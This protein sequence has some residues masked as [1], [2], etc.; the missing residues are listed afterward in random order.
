MQYATDFILNTHATIG[1]LWFIVASIVVSI[2]LC[3]IAIPMTTNLMVNQVAGLA[4]RWFGAKTRTL[5]INASTNNPELASMVVSMGIGRM[6]GW[7]NPCGSL[8]A[9]GYLMY[10]FAPIWFMLI[11][12][13]KGK[14]NLLGEFFKLLRAE[15][16]LVM[17]HI[18]IA[19]GAFACG[20][21]ALWLMRSKFGRGE[22]PLTPPNETTELAVNATST[23]VLQST[24]ATP[25]TGLFMF[26]ALAILI[27]GVALVFYFEHRLKKKRP[28]LFTDIHD[29]HHGDSIFLFIVGT[30]GLI[31]ACWVMNTM[32]LAW[33]A[34]YSDTLSSLLGDQVFAGLHYF[35]GALITSLPELNV[36]L[37]NYRRL[38]VPDLNT[39]LGSASYSNLTNL[40]IVLLGLAVFTGLASFGLVL[41]WE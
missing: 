25:N 24:G 8:L 1:D 14:F 34:L 18:S 35:L 22:N 20:N 5:V 36:A 9:N 32:F 10:L 27:V 13:V 19:L 38:T 6:G 28:N 41:P 21:V 23:N 40:V 11:L 33:T 12:V 26:A 16:R 17:W 31:I 29:E 39:A 15:K 2:V 3:F 37:S 4:R 7:A 30:L